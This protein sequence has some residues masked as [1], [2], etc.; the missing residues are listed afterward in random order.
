[1]TL[2]SRFLPRLAV[3]ALAALAFL[4]PAGAEPRHPLKPLLW[5][6]EGPGVKKP[7]YLFGTIHIAKSPAATLHPAAQKAF[8]E[9][10]ALHTE[11]PFDPATQTASIALV[12]RTDGKELSESIGRHLSKQ[13][14]AEVK[15]INPELDLTP[16]ETVKTWYV[17]YLLPM[18]PFLLEGEKPLDMRLWDEATTAGKKTA[19]MQTPEDQIVGFQELT[20]EEQTIFLAD[21]LRFLKEGRQ[22]KKDPMGKLIEAYISGDEERIEAEAKESIELTLKGDHK[23][24]GERLIKRI[25]SD[26]DLIMADY[27]KATLEKSPEG[28][29]FFAA[30]AAHYCGKTGVRWHLEQKGYKITRIGG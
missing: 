27:I 30:G 6:I 28:I 22:E 12:T 26:R 2:I 25:L 15:E 4:A 11:C 5:K 7:S 3:P 24:L 17:A 1:M 19:G 21:T 14:M 29:H 23:E 13:V 20:E 10:T 16:F 8:G 18:L 9:S